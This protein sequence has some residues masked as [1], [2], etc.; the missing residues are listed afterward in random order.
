LGG[1]LGPLPGLRFLPVMAY[2]RRSLEVVSKPL[3]TSKGGFS[4]DAGFSVDFIN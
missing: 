3:Q 1:P 4:N 2:R